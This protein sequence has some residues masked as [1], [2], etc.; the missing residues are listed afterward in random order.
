MATPLLLYTPLLLLPTAA[1]W[2]APAARPHTLRS[3]CCV[4]SAAEDDGDVEDG[5]RVGDL[6]AEIASRQ[7]REL[8][9]ED[10]L[11]RDERI[12]DAMLANGVNS[13]FAELAELDADLS[14]V[15]R[16][17]SAVLRSELE[18]AEAQVLERYD[19]EL[20]S[21]QESALPL[22]QELREEMLRTLQA[23]RTYSPR[24][25]ENPTP[26]YF[27]RRNEV[28]PKAAAMRDPLYLTCE[29]AAAAAG[30]LLFVAVAD[31]AL[32]APGSCDA[33]LGAADRELLV[34]VWR[35]AF[36]AAAATYLSTVSVLLTKTEFNQFV[37]P[38]DD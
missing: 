38:R 16:N 34:N 5:L 31:A 9:P 18:R 32:G 28:R 14:L 6:L 24:E 33:A 26:F 37:E 36:A 10:M 11:A 20:A 15:E 19:A 4:S 21:L 8:S 3:R 17:T 1:A 30:A 12:I 23:I 27:G 29:R 35:V 7:L 13:M 2:H 25:V 22:K